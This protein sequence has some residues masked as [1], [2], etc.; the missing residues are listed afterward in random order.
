MLRTAND[1]NLL[2]TALY[3]RM[4]TQQQTDSPEQQRR[5]F[6]EMRQR[7]GLAKVAE[8][9]DEGK[10][11]L[12]IKNRPAF[13]KMLADATAGKFKAIAI[14]DINRLSREDSLAASAYVETIRKAGVRLFTNRREIALADS[15]SR[16]MLCLEQEGANDYSAK[17]SEVL[18][19]RIRQ[20]LANG[21]PFYSNCPFGYDKH[22]FDGQRL[23][24][25]VSFRERFSRPRLWRVEYR[26]SQE[27][28]AVEAVRWL[29]AEVVKGSRSLNDITRDFNKRVAPVRARKWDRETLIRILANPFYTGGV[30]Q[31]FF[32]GKGKFGAQICD[33]PFIIWNHHQPIIPRKLFDAVQVALEDRRREKY[34]PRESGYFLRGLLRCGYC[35]K[36]MTSHTSGNRGYVCHH[37]PRSTTPCVRD[38]RPRVSASIIE[39]LVVSAV[40]DL[41]ADRSTIAKLERLAAQ[42]SRS[43]ANGTGP[44]ALAKR[45]DKLR[46]MIERGEANLPLAASADDFRTISRSLAEWRQELATIEHSPD[47]SHAVAARTTPK[48]AVAR[49][50]SVLRELRKADP[51]K[52]AA[53]L[54]SVVESVTVKHAVGTNGRKVRGYWEGEIVFK[55]ELY[56]RPHRFAGSG[57]KNATP[58][59]TAALVRNL[60]KGK[61]VPLRAIYE[62]MGVPQGTGANRV[63]SALKQGLVKRVKWGEYVPA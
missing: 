13:Q 20:N 35:G 8:Y 31:G 19:R 24:R 56:L 49:I 5:A 28:G 59:Q 54:H 37:G 7:Y 12:S 46:G 3:I 23:I 17:I 36:C 62:S 52:T 50:A 26:P 57:R 16:I 29:F 34:R 4:S 44:R 53:L 15:M 22:I 10:S 63:C 11:G 2:P 6:E 58:E 18:V 39:P 14:W 42:S 51:D 32:G 41:F 47:K 43:T 48:M 21:I 45:A 55:A 60:Y 9:L 33:E 38:N 40:T 27:P 25:V 30:R 1:K 61:P